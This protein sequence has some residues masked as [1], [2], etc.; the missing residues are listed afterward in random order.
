M[1]GLSDLPPDPAQLPL[2]WF[3]DASEDDFGR[4]VVLLEPLS[5]TI[6]WLGVPGRSWRC[7]RFQLFERVAEEP[8]LN[9]SPLTQQRVGW[10]RVIVPEGELLD[11]IVALWVKDPGQLRPAT[12]A[13]LAALPPD[14]AAWS[15]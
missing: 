10:Q 7:S 3:S 4:L 6:P 8:D 2:I 1:T 9:Q 5:V 12:A 15:F 14:T 13:E 11:R